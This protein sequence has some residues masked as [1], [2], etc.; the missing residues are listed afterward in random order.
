MNNRANQRDRIL[1]SRYSQIGLNADW[2]V[3]T[4]LI[5]TYRHESAYCTD[6]DIILWDNEDGTF[7]CAV[8]KWYDDHSE[9]FHYGDVFASAG[10][11]IRDAAGWSK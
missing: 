7:Q 2:C 5:G 11:A 8:V 3:P 4:Y 1:C 6:S 10:A 9:I